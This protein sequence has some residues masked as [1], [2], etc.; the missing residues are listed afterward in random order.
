MQEVKEAADQLR[1]ILT[2]IQ[3]ILDMKWCIRRKLSILSTLPEV[4][5]FSKAPGQLLCYAIL[6]VIGLR[7]HCVT[8]Y[9]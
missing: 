7:S 4:P 2:S 3:D 1:K 9:K 5:D 8:N 6:D